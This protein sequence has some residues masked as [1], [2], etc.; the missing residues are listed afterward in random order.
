MPRWYLHAPPDEVARGM[1]DELFARVMPT[2]PPARPAPKVEK[3]QKYVRRQWQ[4]TELDEIAVGRLAW[5]EPW[6]AESARPLLLRYFKSLQVLRGP[7]PST[8]LRG[9]LSERLGPWTLQVLDL[10][11]ETRLRREELR[12]VADALLAYPAWPRQRSEPLWKRRAAVAGAVR[13]AL[14][15]RHPTQP[16]PPAPP[17]IIVAAFMWRWGAW[18]VDPEEPRTVK[19]LEA[20]YSRWRNPPEPRAGGPRRARPGRAR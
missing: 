18:R 7:A 6:R 5:S 1:L 13:Q 2:A 10:A 12:Q 20:A 8:M 3:W 4:G 17:W 9:A 16:E 15:A 11:D 19:V 14:M